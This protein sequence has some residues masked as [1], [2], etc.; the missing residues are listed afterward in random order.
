MQYELGRGAIQSGASYV[1]EQLD[2][3]DYKGIR[4]YFELDN[5]YLIRKLFLIL[6]P[7]KYS[8]NQVQP[9]DGHHSSNLYRP[10]LYIPAMSLITLVLFKGF[11]T[12]SSHIF[13]PDIPFISFS[14]LFSFHLLVCM[15]YKAVGY[16]F[17][18][19]FGFLDLVAL[20]GYKFVVA[21]I[22]RWLFNYYSGLA[23]IAYLFIAFFFF[24]SRSLKRVMNLSVNTHQQLHILF[25]IAFLEMFSILLIC[26]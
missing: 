22:V 9:S 8:E 19:S 21:I 7:F 20:L 1:N 16:I 15:F 14:R 24:I 4:K 10:D 13:H 12:G 11:R 26:R 3:V 25:G 17:G 6:F 23:V 5:Q 2:K 18:S